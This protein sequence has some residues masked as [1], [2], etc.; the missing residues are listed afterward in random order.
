MWFIYLLEADGCGVLTVTGREW[1][2]HTPAGENKVCKNDTRVYSGISYIDLRE[3][4]DEFSL[5]ETIEGN[6]D[7]FLQEGGSDE[8]IKQAMLPIT[9][10]KLIGCLPD[11][12]FK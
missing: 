9:I 6:L 8:E 12:E 2:V 10:Q 1:V 3:H 5:I 11:Q 4:V 7:K